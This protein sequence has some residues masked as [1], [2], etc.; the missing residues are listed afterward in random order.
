MAAAICGKETFIFRDFREF[1]SKN[2]LTINGNVYDLS[3]YSKASNY[4]MTL[5]TP[6]AGVSIYYNPQYLQSQYCLKGNITIPVDYL[7]ESSTGDAGLCTASYR[8]VYDMLVSPLNIQA[9]KLGRTT[10]PWAEIETPSNPHN[11]PINTRFKPF[12]I[13]NKSL[14]YKPI[15]PITTSSTNIQSTTRPNLTLSNPNPRSRYFP[16]HLLPR[17]PQRYRMFHEPVHRRSH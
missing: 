2:Y 11:P 16:Y 17:S 5:L 15:R 12:S 8:G 13:Q 14:G 6:L 7:C 4:S 1:K 3:A 9:Y 10:I